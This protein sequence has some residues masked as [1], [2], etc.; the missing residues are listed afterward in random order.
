MLTHRRREREEDVTTP[1]EL[2]CAS[3]FFADSAG[4]WFRERTLM[5]IHVQRGYAL[6]W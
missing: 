1:R 5:G 4:N 6:S 2:S 3:E